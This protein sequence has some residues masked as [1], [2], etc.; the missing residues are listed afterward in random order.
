MKRLKI[1]IATLVI[2]ALAITAVA[3]AAQTPSATGTPS[4]PSA[5][6]TDQ[7]QPPAGPGQRPGRGQGQGFGMGGELQVIADA[8][9]EDMA[10]LRTDLQGGKTIAD[11][12]KEKNVELSTVE[13]AVVAKVADNLKTAVTDGRLTQEQADAQTALLKANLT[14]LFNRKM[15]MPQGQGN[16]NGPGNGQRTNPVLD[17][18]ATALGED[19][20]TL[21]TD[22]KA[23]KTIADIAKEKN[24][25]LST[26]VDAVVAQRQTAITT[27]VTDGRLTQEQADAQIA[28]L[29]ADL[30]A[31]FAKKMDAN[32]RGGFAFGGGF[33]GPMGGFGGGFGG[34]GRPGGRPNGNGGPMGPGGNNGNGGP[35]NNAPPAPDATPEA[36]ANA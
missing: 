17:V 23:G 32:G 5:E 36:T 6:A 14:A 20:A 13:D 15:Q 11:I 30:D 29:K 19:A 27:A 10:T 22:L 2:A 34:P 7:S 21:Q 28:L 16:G 33:G 25:E 3:V 4:Q 9:G 12:A 18:I 31:A 26:V 35:G 8:L 24:V 1:G